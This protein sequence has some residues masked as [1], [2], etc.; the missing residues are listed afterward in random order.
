[1]KIVQIISG[2]YHG[3]AQKFVVDLSNELLAKGHDVT[4]LSLHGGNEEKEFNKQFLHDGVH[5][6]CFKIEE[7]SMIRILKEVN[8]YLYLLKPDIIH[9]HLAVIQYIIP[10]IVFTKYKV[11]HTLH[12]LAQYADGGGGWHAKLYKF[13]YKAKLVIPIT[14]SDECHR[15]FSEYYHL[16]C[17]IMI[18]NGCEQ[19]E[20][21]SDIEAVRKEVAGYK[22]SL[23]TKV[24]I[25]VARFHEAKNQKLLVDSFN[26]LYEKGID[27]TL[28]VLGSGFDSN[29]A[30]EITSKA[31]SKIHFIGPKNN[32]GDYLA[33]S[34]AFCL[35]S[36][37]EGLPISLLEALSMNV[38]P[39]CTP[40]GGIVNVIEDE[41]SG[42]L[43]SDLTIESYVNAVLRYLRDYKGQFELKALYK[44]NYSMES[45]AKKYLDI[46]R[47]ALQR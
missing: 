20:I 13:M 9:C 29:E 47:Q 17:D 2:L 27:F 19:A 6:K 39:I 4:V 45:C 14:I 24:F 30:K 38:V 28:L 43:S 23:N 32:V 1:M 31:C 11:F 8:N 44:N 25:H 41:K 46:Y 10:T 34:D 7:M 35:S 12:S 42:Y 3:G 33:C 18:P 15:S 21:T 26:S 5:Y 37:Y 16:N 22:S 36:L 40:V